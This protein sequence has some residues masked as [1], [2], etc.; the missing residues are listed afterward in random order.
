MEE[1]MNGLEGKKT[2]NSIVSAEQKNIEARMKEKEKQTNVGAMEQIEQDEQE[3]LNVKDGRK[4]LKQAFS[5]RKENRAT[6]FQW[7]QKGNGRKS[8]C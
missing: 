6:H 8:A 3:N 4:A 1:I 7:N 2:I 5:R